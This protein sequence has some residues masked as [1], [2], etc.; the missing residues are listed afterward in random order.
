M[1]KHFEHDL[2]MVGLK[3]RMKK[4]A[5]LELA[6]KCPIKNIVLAREQENKYDINAIRVSLGGVHLG[7]IRADTAAILAKAM[8]DGEMKFLRATL[9]RLVDGTNGPASDGRLHVVFEDR[10]P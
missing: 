10:R 9:T 6:K 1:T 4:E 5:R 7:Y 3:F 2:D 8:D